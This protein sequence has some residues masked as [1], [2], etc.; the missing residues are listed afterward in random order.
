MIISRRTA[1]EV[2]LRGL[3]P[4]LLFAP[5]SGN[6][7]LPRVACRMRENKE[8]A[9][10][11]ITSATSLSA[12]SVRLGASIGQK[13]GVVYRQPPMCAGPSRSFP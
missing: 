12:E 1:A 5:P 9:L 2:S 6:P 11:V 4:S 13:G 8:S 7:A 3:A 10:D